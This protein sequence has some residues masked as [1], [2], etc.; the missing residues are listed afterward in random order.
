MHQLQQF[1]QLETDVAKCRSP[2]ARQV[3]N[4]G[5]VTICNKKVTRKALT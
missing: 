5:W 2:R 1:G 3:G 4:L